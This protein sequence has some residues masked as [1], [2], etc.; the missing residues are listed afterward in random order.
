MQVFAIRY[1]RWFRWMSVI[2]GL[3]PRWSRVAIDGDR[4]M[5]R[6]SYAF[7]SEFPVSAVRSVRPW[8]GLVWGWGVHGWRGRW[9]VNGSSHGIVV[10]ELDPPARAR[11]L[12]FSIRVRELAIS[13]ED[14]VGFASALGLRLDT[15]P[16]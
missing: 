8:T 4:V 2:G 16:E 13:V 11:V 14:P 12:G 15:A 5:V 7:S 10:V 1:D 9:L 6:M 3:V